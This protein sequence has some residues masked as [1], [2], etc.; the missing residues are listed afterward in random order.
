MGITITQER[1]DSPDA[2]TL[3]KE[4]SDYLDHPYPKW[5]QLD[6]SSDQLILEGVAFFV[7]RV[8]GTPAG[9]GGVKFCPRWGEL[10]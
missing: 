9:C 2:V 3:I 4:L 5:N 10:K 7:T 1:P 6:L 8:D